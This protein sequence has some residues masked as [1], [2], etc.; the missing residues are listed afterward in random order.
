VPQTVAILLILQTALAGIALFVLVDG[1]EWVR[2][3]IRAIALWAV[4]IGGIVGLTL[5]IPWALTEWAGTAWSFVGLTGAVCL[6]PVLVMGRDF[7]KRY[8]HRIRQRYLSDA[9]EDE[10]LLFDGQIE[11]GPFSTAELIEHVSNGEITASDH[12]WK[13]GMDSWRP[14]YATGLQ[15]LAVHAEVVLSG[16]AVRPQG[17]LC[18]RGWRDPG[19]DNTRSGRAPWGREC[20]SG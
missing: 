3:H 18:R 5:A 8:S 13:P 14:V 9:A 17:A 19:R 1:P 11:R 6:C 15:R 10:W 20:S 16:T 7:W 4:L 2:S 12:V